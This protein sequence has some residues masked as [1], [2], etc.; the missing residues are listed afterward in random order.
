MF[1][2]VSISIFVILGSFERD[3]I[4]YETIQRRRVNFQYIWNEYP[5]KTF[6][7][8]LYLVEQPNELKFWKSFLLP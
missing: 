2:R 8:M 1:I 6:N 4:V 3:Q 5:I 7:E